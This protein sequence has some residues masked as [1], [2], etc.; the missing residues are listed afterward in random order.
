ML[1]FYEELNRY[2][3]FYQFYQRRVQTLPKWVEKAHLTVKSSVF[4]RSHDSQR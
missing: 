2:Q 1:T 3:L 4:K